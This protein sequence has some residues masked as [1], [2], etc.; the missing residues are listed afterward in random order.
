M[1]KNMWLPLVKCRLCA[2]SMISLML[3]AAMHMITTENTKHRNKN[4]YHS[5]MTN[6]TCSIKQFKKKINTNRWNSVEPG[7]IEVKWLT[8]IIP[9]TQDGTCVNNDLQPTSCVLPYGT[10]HQHRKSKIIIACFP[11]FQTGIGLNIDT[12]NVYVR[13]YLLHLLLR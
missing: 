1:L 4:S 9:V 10:W 7:G 8:M 6:K 5:A 3:S 13:T 12:T 2:A 11:F